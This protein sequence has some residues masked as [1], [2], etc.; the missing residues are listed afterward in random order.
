MATITS[1]PVEIVN[2]FLEGLPLADL[3]SFRL[4]CTTNETKS[5]EYFRKTHFT[6][7][8]INIDPE[9]IARLSEIAKN[10]NLGCAI[11]TLIVTFHDKGL[12]WAADSPTNKLTK[13]AFRRR[14]WRRPLNK[15][16]ESGLL[17]T[18]YLQ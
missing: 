17:E 4:T 15:L 16:P 3:R 10:K 5:F 8:V 9:N 7:K 12:R 13:T 18:P 1:C 2:L 6:Q 14:I 11:Q